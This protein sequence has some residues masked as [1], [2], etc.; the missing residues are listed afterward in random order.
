MDAIGRVA[1]RHGLAVIED[2]AHGCWGATAG[3]G[4][5]RREPWP[6]SVSTA[7][8]HHLR[9]RGAL[10]LNEEG[11]QPRR[12]RARKGPTAAFLPRRGGSHTWV[13]PAPATCSPMYWRPTSGAPRCGR[14]Q[15]ARSRVACP[16]NALAPHA[17]ALGF[18][19]PTVPAECEPAYHL[20]YLLLRDEPVRERLIAALRARSIRAISHYQPLHLS[21]AGR[22]F[23]RHLGCPVTESVCERVLR[24]PLYPTLRADERRRSSTWF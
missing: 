10:L 20:F 12:D 15:A 17:A 1:A 19:V 2:N 9:R 3:V 7:Q 21:L 14:N 11:H 22:R 24:L 4:W 16:S 8:E 6:A 23:G 18:Q 5:G 13:G